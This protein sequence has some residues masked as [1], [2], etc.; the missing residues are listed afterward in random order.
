MPV[1]G[2]TRGGKP[3]LGQ[4]VERLDRHGCRREVGMSGMD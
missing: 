1:I 2:E 4:G 3:W